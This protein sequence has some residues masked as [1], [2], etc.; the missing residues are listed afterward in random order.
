MLD[1]GSRMSQKDERMDDDLFS[2]VSDETVQNE[3]P[4]PIEVETLP[5]NGAVDDIFSEPSAVVEEKSIEQPEIEAEPKAPVRF[6]FLRKAKNHD[7]EFEKLDTCK[8]LKSA[9]LESGL[10]LEQVESVTQIRGK[11]LEALEAGDF[12][13]LPQQVY[14]LAYLRKLCRLYGISAKDEEILVAPWRQIVKEVPDNLPA[15]VIPDEDSENSKILRRLEFGLLAGGAIVVIGIV[16]F[17]VIL[18][19]SFFRGGTTPTP[20]F[21]NTTLLE[22]QEKPVLT[23]PGK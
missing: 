20:K 21:D 12:G 17:L 15:S 6:S 10:S 7:D 8:I 1:F 9:R 18:A 5:S 2:T 11:Y 4:E 22:L 19:V 13:H 14:V 3:P 16:A 23:I